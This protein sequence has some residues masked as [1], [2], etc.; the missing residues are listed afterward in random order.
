MRESHRS[1]F[2]LRHD[3][4]IWVLDKQHNVSPVGI[5]TCYTK[6]DLILNE[7]LMHVYSQV[8]CTIRVKFD[9]YIL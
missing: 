3:V 4:C 2:F 9:S 5:C 7:T 6:C 8:E 1:G